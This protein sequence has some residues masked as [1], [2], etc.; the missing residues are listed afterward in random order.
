MG[1]PTFL[2]IHGMTHF[3]NSWG[4]IPHMVLEDRQSAKEGIGDESPSS[5]VEHEERRNN[6]GQKSTRKLL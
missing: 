4:C 6:R 3:R 1:I 2:E 5:S